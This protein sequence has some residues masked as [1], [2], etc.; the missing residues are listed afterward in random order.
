[1]SILTKEKEYEIRAQLENLSIPSIDVAKVLAELDTVRAERD[2]LA[3]LI[4]KMASIPNIKIE[5]IRT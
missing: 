4:L 5:D 1:M 3:T 2:S